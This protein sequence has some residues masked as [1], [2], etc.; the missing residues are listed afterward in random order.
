MAASELTP[1]QKRS[2]RSIVIAQGCSKL[3][4]VASS[5]KTV[6]RDAEKINY[7]I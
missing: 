5:A 1:T 4:D 7:P 6:L 3:A 2:A